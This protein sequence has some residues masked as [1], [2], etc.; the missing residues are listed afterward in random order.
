MEDSNNINNIFR[1]KFNSEA[2]PKEDWNTPDDQVWSNIERT[3]PK[4]KEE[5]NRSPLIPFILS[6]ALLGFMFWG[7][8]YLQKAEEV[9]N[10]EHLLKQC[11]DSKIEANGNTHN[12]N[13]SIMASHQNSAEK[14]EPIVSMVNQK[15]AN[16]SNS[17]VTS[18]ATFKDVN[19]KSNISSL[20]GEAAN[21]LLASA[22]ISDQEARIAAQNQIDDNQ[23]L[24][25]NHDESRPNLKIIPLQ[26]LIQKPFVNNNSY[27]D[28]NQLNTQLSAINPAL[29]NSGP[30]MLGFGV[31]YNQWIDKKN[32][33]INN[34]LSEL[35]LNEKTTPSLH[36]QV[37]LKKFINRQLAVNIGLGTYSRNQRSTYRLSLPYSTSNEVRHGDE[38]H[39]YFQHSLPTSLGNINTN[40]TLARS[41]SSNV[42]NNENVDLDFSLSNKIKALNVPITFI[43]YLQNSGQGLYF[44]TGLNTEFIFQQTLTNVTTNSYHSLVDDREMNVAFDRKQIERFNFSIPLGIGYSKNIGS[45]ISIDLSANYGFGLNN[46]HMHEGFTHKID[47]ISTQI[48]VFKSL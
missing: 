23:S 3:L 11:S 32:G 34:P 1:D 28:L 15:V 13:Q 30:W 24:V 45:D 27:F 8:K 16:A 18:S 22:T 7:Y 46:V 5:S 25:E 38:M 29:K 36:Y 20:K 26:N 12:T 4:P 43:F 10:L 42:T 31:G 48:A 39:N 35:L 33:T 47:R 14:I 2:I 41:I 37:N 19:Q 6:L 44:E 9:E 40:L 21:D 17:D